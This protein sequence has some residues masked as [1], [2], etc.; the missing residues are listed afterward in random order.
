MP[1]AWSD[2]D[3]RQ[4]EHIRDSQLDRG[5]SREEAEEVAAR[6]VNKHRRERGDT[7][8]KTTQGTGNPNKPLGERSKDELYN[9][10]KELGVEGRSKMSKDEL[11]QAIR[12]RE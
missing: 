1:D 9:R 8:N 11:V 4:Y 2:K 5:S 3:E 12:K 7:P 6:T 10:A